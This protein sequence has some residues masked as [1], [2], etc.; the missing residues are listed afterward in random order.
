MAG[1]ETQSHQHLGGMLK[2]T[3]AEQDLEEPQHLGGRH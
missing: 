3:S 1:E 2:Q